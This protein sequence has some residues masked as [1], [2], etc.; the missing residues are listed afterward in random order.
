MVLS[1]AEVVR[2]VLISPTKILLRVH[3]AALNPGG[4][5]MMQF[6]PS[7]L[8]TK[9]CIPELDVAGEVIEVGVGVPFHRDL[10]PGRRVI[11]SIPVADHLKGQGA[12]AEYITIEAAYVVEAPR[13]LSLEEASGL[14]IAGCTALA[15]LSKA[16]LTKGQRVLV[17]GAGGGIGTLV[18]QMVRDAIGSD[19]FL[20]A[21]CSAEKQT[22]L[23]DLG[24]TEVSD[25]PTTG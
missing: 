14:P 11:G 24:A 1:L 7:I 21:V 9:P 2:P 8:R 12:L 20:V 3:Y 23:R 15:L 25:L 17:N 16:R 4:S 19:G 10:A 22:L 6:C 18:T 5:I 13:V